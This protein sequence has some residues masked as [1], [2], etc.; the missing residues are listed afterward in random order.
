MSREVLES[1]G[2]IE[3]SE[4]NY[5]DL[6]LDDKNKCPSRRRQNIVLGPQK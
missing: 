3:A 6:A 1:W 2:G 5:D 4:E